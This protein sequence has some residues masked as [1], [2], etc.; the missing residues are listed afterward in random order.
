[1]NSMR[2]FENLGIQRQIEAIGTPLGIYGR[3]DGEG[4]ALATLNFDSLRTYQDRPTLGVNYLELERTL[5]SIV[6]EKMQ[7]QPQCVVESI[8][9]PNAPDT[10]MALVKWISG[11][12]GRQD[13]KKGLYDC[14]IVSDGPF[15]ISREQHWSGGFDLEGVATLFEAVIPRPAKIMK[16]YASDQWGMDRRVGFFPF[17]GAARD[18]LYVYAQIPYDRNS[19]VGTPNSSSSSS[20]AKETPMQQKVPATAMLEH[21]TDFGGAWRDI[22]AAVSAQPSINR[23]IVVNGNF[24]SGYGPVKGRVVAMGDTSISIPTP[25][26]GHELGIATDMAQYLANS[27]AFNSAPLLTGIYSLNQS[28][29]KL[30]PIADALR[31]ELKAAIHFRSSLPNFFKRWMLK[32]SYSDRTLAAQQMEFLGLKLS[33]SEQQD[34]LA[35]NRIQTLRKEWHQLDDAGREQSKLHFKSELDKQTKAMEKELFEL[36]QA[37]EA[38][39]AQQQQQQH[40]QQKA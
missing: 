8:E 19:T 32:S 34:L 7:I 5:Q 25:C 31:N 33:R 3:S 27:I 26:L 40:Q 38:Q 16:G 14:V 22:A 36:A 6:S 39:K 30:V 11:F 21:F 23:T 1:M 2:V 28:Y 12:L 37:Q 4:N 9:S 13:Q 15:S 35:L 18:Q 17:G 20:S 29:G 24:K 10:R